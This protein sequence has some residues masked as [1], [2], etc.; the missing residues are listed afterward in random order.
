[1]GKRQVPLFVVFTT[2]T[3][4]CARAR[5]SPEDSGGRDKT[6]GGKM[7]GYKRGWGSASA[8]YE[9][10]DLSPQGKAGSELS[11]LRRSRSREYC[12]PVH[13]RFPCTLVCET[14]NLATGTTEIRTA[15]LKR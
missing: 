8:K 13:N 7:D 11:G 4:T 3:T 6:I 5:L 9:G 1:M 15:I 12:S 2:T 14:K 10:T